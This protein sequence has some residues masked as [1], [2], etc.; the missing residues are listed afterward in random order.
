[1]PIDL[2][3]IPTV[4]EARVEGARS[5]SPS[6]PQYQILAETFKVLSHPTRL[7]ILHALTRDEFCVC[8]LAALLETSVSAVRHQLRMM[9]AQRL[10][11]SRR[12]GKL[13]YYALD[14]DHVRQLYAAGLDHVME[15]SV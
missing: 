12:E 10:V 9:R 1:M 3:D 15:E 8:D 6:A 5:S 14:D 7:K 4:D 11:R 2:C 13:V